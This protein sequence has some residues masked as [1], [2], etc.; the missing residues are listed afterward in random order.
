MVSSSNVFF[1]IQVIRNII[2]F[3]VMTPFLVVM[4]ISNY[5]KNTNKS[6]LLNFVEVFLRHGIRVNP[7]GRKG[8]FEVVRFVTSFPIFD[9]FGK[10]NS[11]YFNIQQMVIPVASNVEHHWLDKTAVDFKGEMIYSDSHGHQ[12]PTEGKNMC[13]YVHG[14]AYH[15][16]SPQT[17]RSFTCRIVKETNVSMFVLDQKLAPEFEFKESIL[18][19]VN[20][21]VHFTNLKYKVTIMG[22]SSGGGT[23]MS[24]FLVIKDLKITQPFSIILLSPWLDLSISGPSWYENGGKC[25]LEYPMLGLDDVA[26]A[27]IHPMKTTNS[28]V[29]PLFG[30][31]TDCKVPILI[32]TGYDEL[33]RDD[34]IRLFLKMKGE[35]YFLKSYTPLLEQWDKAA[36]REHYIRKSHENVELQIFPHSFHFFQIFGGR[37]SSLAVS[38]IKYF[39]LAPNKQ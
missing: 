16:L 14:G 33:I 2:Y 15:F 32:Q 39:M 22:D 6:L 28:N 5:A 35:D 25:F 4:A 19:V 38:E 3:T 10:F 11:K 9:Y 30:D 37:Y 27:M 26:A 21:Y 17:H 24:A 1:T 23:L 31:L 34:S 29:S 12:F 20:A 8:A 18:D 36:F 7:P 13:L